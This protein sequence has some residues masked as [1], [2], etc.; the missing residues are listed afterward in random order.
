MDF[1]SAA[2]LDRPT[3][4]GIAVAI[5][6]TSS[7]LLP[8]PHALLIITSDDGL[9]SIYDYLWVARILLQFTNL[10][11]RLLFHVIL[12]D[13]DWIFLPGLSSFHWTLWT[14]PMNKAESPSEKPLAVLSS[15][16]QTQ[17]F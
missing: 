6:C 11:F 8:I 13:Y 3:S 14:G 4:M 12:V 16:R 2:R 7:F 1:Y 17:R 5:P 9:L 10:W 15:L